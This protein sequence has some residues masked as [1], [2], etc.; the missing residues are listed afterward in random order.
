LAD[1]VYAR[2]AARNQMQRHYAE[3]LEAIIKS[4]RPQDGT[5]ADVL[6]NPQVSHE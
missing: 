5:A 1:D 2:L 4:T 6:G 3:R